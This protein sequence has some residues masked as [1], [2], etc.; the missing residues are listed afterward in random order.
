[1]S[2]LIDAARFHRLLERRS[3]LGEYDSGGC[4]T[5]CALNYEAAQFV[6]ILIVFL[7]ARL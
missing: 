5:N 3:I 7:I 2:L 1:M 4:P 6:G